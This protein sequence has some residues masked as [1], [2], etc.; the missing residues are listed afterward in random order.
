VLQGLG[1][2]GVVGSICPSQIADANAPDYA[3][4]PVIASLLD[5]AKDHLQ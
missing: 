1:A 5:A 2:Q 4:R 3:Y